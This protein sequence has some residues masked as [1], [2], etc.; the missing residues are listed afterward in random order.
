MTRRPAR[1][2]WLLALCL[3]LSLPAKADAP[4]TLA[5]ALAPATAPK[6]G[7]A[8]S[9]GAALVPLPEGA[10][11]PG[12]ALSVSETAALYEKQAPAFG[13]VVAVA[14]RSHTVVYSPPETPNPYDGMAPKQ[15]LKMLAATF[16]AAQWKA[17]LS[18]VGVSYADM[19]GETQPP[20]F[21]ALFPGG[22]LLCIRDNP[23][24]PN[25]PNSKRDISG[26]ALT[27]A[28]LRLSYTVS[29]ALQTVDNPDSHIFAGSVA[30]DG[31]PARFFMLNA[32]ES[33]VDREF[34]ATVREKVPNVLKPGQVRFDAPVWQVPVPLD[35]GVRTV[36]DLVA[37]I[38]RAARVELYADPRYGKRPVT[39]TGAAHSARAADLLRALA[40]CVGG[41]YRQVGPAAVLTD[42]L[43]GLGTRHA[44]WKDFE[45]KAR[46]LQPGGDDVF[47]AAPTVAGTAY[48]V[49]DIPSGGDPLAF[50]AEQRKD[51]WKEWHANPMQSSS[52]M[53]D[54]TLP[55][56]RLS[57]AQQEAARMIA[58]QDE[59][60]HIAVNLDGT[61]MVQA[62]PD[63]QILL[64][65]L[66]GPVLVF[67]SYDGL[68]PYPAQTPVDQE[69]QRKRAG[70]TFPFLPPPGPATPPPDLRQSLRGFDRRAA[71][72]AP[73]TGTELSRSLAALKALGFNEAWLEVTPG[74]Q[75]EGAPAPEALLAQA[76]KEGKAAG[77]TVLPDLRLLHWGADTPPALLDRDLRGRT[78]TEAAKGARFPTADTA[79]TVTPFAPE[80]GRRLA[81][82]VRALGSVGGVGGM[83][84]EGLTPIGYETFA[85]DRGESSYGDPLGY[86]EAGRLASLRSS[87]A[88]PVDLYTNSYTDERAHVQVPGFDGGFRQERVLYD[89]WRAQRVQAVRDLAKLL[90]AALPP[91]PLRLLVPP[92]NASFGSVYGSWDDRRLPPPDVQYI[93]PTGP[94]G[95]PLMGVSST[96]RMPSALSYHVVQV[97]AFP[98]K[99]APAWGEAAARALLAAAK[100]G[101]R[102]VVLDT[103]RRPRLLEELA[104]AE[105]AP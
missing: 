93:S 16:T 22:H 68:L 17:F 11:L 41:A 100:N 27:S 10:T 3:P 70:D 46:A 48:T 14:P 12:T 81:A 29:L 72:I 59:K 39:L 19:A 47:A 78:P 21:Q 32:Q 98:D 56:G 5:Q 61:V 55:L 6:T 65:A 31:A 1:H 28:H 105:K 13:D 87:H 103:V 99:P 44:L 54:V 15:V 74:A 33:N 7:V 4:P 83:V 67:Q 104:E 82:L 75:P 91:R 58:L 62:E 85:A 84:W 66:D 80:V 90:A 92:A 24:G 52:A 30:P 8:L 94:D 96:E 26:D 64:P 23:S 77:I 73:K 97:F 34:G 76:V 18:P 40:L 9:V 89:G 25:D 37:R 69:T 60:Q 43:V 101:V 49:Q 50:T 45:E 36:D 42:D 2:A 53:M 57:P 79:D 88:D 38:G 51:F 95:K 35:G 20:L 86:A 63:L 71:R 102:N